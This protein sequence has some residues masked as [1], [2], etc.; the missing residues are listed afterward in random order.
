MIAG[1]EIGLPQNPGASLAN[2]S[3]KVARGTI[4]GIRHW[5]FCLQFSLYSMKAAGR[6]RT[7]RARSASVR[8]HHWRTGCKDPR[9]PPRTRQTGFGYHKCKRRQQP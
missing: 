1:T 9:V 7:A 3:H 2:L 6:R 8:G 5:S 4:A